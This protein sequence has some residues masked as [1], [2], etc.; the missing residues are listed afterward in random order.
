MEEAWALGW[1]LPGE[2]SLWRRMS[3]PDRRHA[4]GVAR[5][6]AS[7]LDDGGPLPGREVMA[8]ALLHDVG[9]VESGLGTFA[10]VGVTLAAMAVGRDRL[11]SPPR[12]HPDHWA[13]PRWFVTI[14]QRAGDYLRHDSIGAAM[15]A[16][17]GADPSTVAW[18][19]EHHLPP[20]RWTLDRRTADALKAADGD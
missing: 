17:A 11:A 13:A 12:D 6:T 20:E 2:Q 19:G 7:L 3:G 14:R 18:A 15:L 10:R 5:G 8:A 16:E 4:A 1:L 9:K